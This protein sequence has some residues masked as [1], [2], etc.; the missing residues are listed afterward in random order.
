[1]KKKKLIALVATAVLG[2]SLIVPLAACSDNDKNN[3]QTS[4]LDINYADYIQDY[5]DYMTST[6]EYK[7]YTKIEAT[8]LSLSEAGVLSS[9]FYS[10]YGVVS[11]AE[12]DANGDTYYMLYNIKTQSYLS[13]THYKY[14]SVDSTYG[15]SIAS[16]DGETYSLIAPNGAVL[17]SGASISVIEFSCYVSG[18]KDVQ[19][20]FKVTVDEQIKYYYAETEENYN[21]NAVAT[22][23]Y[24]AVS[25]NDIS[26]ASTYESDL[27]HP[28]YDDDYEVLGDIADY[29]YSYCG[30]VFSFYNDGEKTSTLDLYDGNSYM[31]YG[32]VSSYF[33][34]AKYEYV[35]ASATSGYNYVKIDEYGTEEKYNYTYYRYN[36]ITDTVEEFAP[37]YHLVN[38]YPVYN[39]TAQTFD[40]VGF[41]GIKYIDGVAYDTES[42]SNYRVV[43]ADDTFSGV[44]DISNKYQLIAPYNTYRLDDSHYINR[45]YNIILDENFNIIYQLPSSYTV[46]PEN[47]CIAIDSSYTTGYNGYYF[48]L[49]DYDGN[50][51]TDTEYSTRPVFYGGYSVVQDATATKL[52]GVSQYV[53]LSANGRK[54]KIT[55]GENETLTRYSGIYV[56]NTYDP[57]DTTNFYTY[58]FYNYSGTLLKTVQGRS[59]SALTDVTN[60]DGSKNIYISITA[61]E[62]STGITSTVV[63]KVS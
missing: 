27:T 38:F 12:R 53:Q 17:V 22:G 13:A 30:S 18:L 34:Y 51:I 49:I 35:A 11:R 63:Y 42:Q 24:I 44:E 10:N 61:V 50:V 41:F 37:A 48:S 40:L 33:Y 4:G 9:S 58:K 14:L 36:F 32:F 43:I 6:S 3:N 54:T 28:V 29:T 23:K 19:N 20:V 8:D 47:K 15:Y 21:G 59:W 2:A 5:A 26:I 45:Y 31:P 57:E 60:S 46:Y 55:L 56:I 7:A 16:T 39:Y 52:E 1:M 62:E 25:I